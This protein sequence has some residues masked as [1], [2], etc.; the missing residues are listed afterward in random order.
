MKC[1]ILGPVTLRDIGR[2]GTEFDAKKAN[3][4]ES[5]IQSPKT[6]DGYASHTHHAPAKLYLKV[7]SPN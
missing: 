5:S 7:N 6:T 3:L 2:A 4:R 1:T